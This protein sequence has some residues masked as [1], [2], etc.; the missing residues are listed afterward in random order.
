MLQKQQVA[1]KVALALQRVK[2]FICWYCVHRNRN[3]KKSIR[4]NSGSCGQGW[5]PAVFFFTR[6]ATHVLKIACAF[7]RRKESKFELRS[8]NG[9]AASHR[10][11]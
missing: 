11:P 8:M 7:Y 3:R 4:D 6:I 5:L 10:L 9:R 2:G 1:S